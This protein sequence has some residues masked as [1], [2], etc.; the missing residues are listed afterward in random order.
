[1]ARL[2]A[3]FT[4]AFLLAAAGMATATNKGVQPQPQLQSFEKLIL[5]NAPSS[6]LR[7]FMPAQAI[8]SPYKLQQW[9]LHLAAYSQKWLAKKG[10]MSDQQLIRELFFDVHRRY[11]KQYTTFTG[12]NAL[13][14][15]GEYNCL[16]ATAFYAL[17]L[18][19]LGYTYTVVESVNHIVLL[20][21]LAEQQLLLET[22]DPT[23]GFL[24]DA[25]TI[26]LRLRE[27]ELKEQ[28]SKYYN[29]NLSIFRTISLKELA[30]LQFFNYAAWHF[31]QGNL[32]AAAIELEKGQL[33]YKS[34]RFSKVAQLL[35][36]RQ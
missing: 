11:L 35:A 30:G 21:N 36:N 13:L 6:D 9:E 24:S 22:T 15:K 7:L 29:L 23:N 26:K 31:N 16:S 19:R 27:M 4:L 32:A 17:M 2:S 8:A 1:M 20:V 28:T 25:H 34:E 33:L 14:E 18:D 10:K 5:L 3:V 12:L